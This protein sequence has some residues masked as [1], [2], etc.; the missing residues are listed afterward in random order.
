MKKFR[1]FSLNKSFRQF[2]S[3]IAKNCS[4]KR[5]KILFNFVAGLLVVLLFGSNIPLGKL[6]LSLFS[7]PVLAEGS[8]QINDS[9]ETGLQHLYEYGN[10]TDV[11]GTTRFQAINKPVYVDIFTAG[12]VINIFACT[13][14]ALKTLR[15]EIYSPVSNPTSGGS[16]GSLVYTTAD[17]DSVSGINSNDIPSPFQGNVESGGDGWTDATGD[18]TRANL[19]SSL[20][21]PLKYTTTT[22]GA[23]EVRF[24]ND[25]DADTMASV[26]QN[27]SISL[28]DITV[29]ANTS[30]APNPQTKQGRVWAFNWAFYSAA[31]N[32]TNATDHNYYIVVP[33]GFSGTN[34]VWQLDL[35][36]FAGGLYE[37]IANNSG[38]NSPNSSGQ[39]VRGLSTSFTGNTASSQYRQYIEYPD[40]RSISPEPASAPVIT[41]FRFEDSAGEDNTISPSSTTG[42]QDSGNFKFTTNTDG[43]YAVIIDVDNDALT[44]N[45]FNPDGQYG[46]GDIILRGNTTG[47]VETS[48][49]WNGKT[50]LGVAVPDGKYQARLYAITGEYHF[51]AGD[52]ESSGGTGLGLTINKANYGSTPSSV[53]TT[54]TEVYWDDMTGLGLAASN[55]TRPSSSLVSGYNSLGAR[56][57][58]GGSSA[59][60]GGN[61]ST[62]APDGASTGYGGN[63]AGFGD[64][65]YLDTYVYGKVTVAETPAIILSS[66]AYVDTP[67][68]DFGDAP[69]TY[70]TNKT[71]SNDG[72]TNTDGVGPSHSIDP[73]ALNLYLG[74]NAPDGESDARTPLTGTGD[75]TGGSTPDDEDGVA[76]FAAIN[77]ATTSY[78]V[79]VKVKNSSGK[80]AYLVGWID[81]NKN[82]KFDSTEGLAYD[83]DNNSTNGTTA[84]ATGTDGNVTLNWTGLSGLVS[85]TTYARFRIS[86]NS[87]LTTSTP[88]GAFIDGEVE[89]YSLTI[90]SA[91]PKLLLVKRITSINNDSAKNPNDNTALNVFVND[92][93]S[94]D[95]DNANWP[96]PKD[97]YLPGAIDGGNVK[98]GDEIEYTIYFLNTVTAAK[99]V[100]MCDLVPTN[101][102]FVQTTYNANSGIGLALNS[103]TLPTAPNSLLTNAADTDAGR[104]YATNDASTPTVCKKFDSSGAVASSGQ[105]AN[106]NGAIVVNVVSGT[107]TLPSA[108][109]AGTPTNS[110]GFVR[111]RAKVN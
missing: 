105:T 29:T 26:T 38:V 70:T 95:D 83:S 12:E 69:D 5:Q 15:V 96:T 21:K 78:S 99:N 63:G 109:A 8:Y 73:T 88:N 3:A 11:G 82:G 33:G 25:S 10:R 48:F 54:T 110:Y 13:N 50:N 27:G 49:S 98:P 67:L 87:G 93:G 2:L 14:Y 81:F 32:D 66:G 80:G 23:Y 65:R 71:P 76:S 6:G 111:F 41:N 103:T 94:T 55:S 90:T 44:S 1:P 58:W 20:L 108:T 60:G 51:L 7:S 36:N 52:V 43:T 62:G 39:I 89:D 79:T 61:G 102:T 72:V 100:T 35:N 92:S 30:T 77:T 4:I 37:I 40:S 28:F 68:L 9:G 106:T 86:T 46:I 104:Y 75:D 84:I 107:T 24:Y 64:L 19:T 42:I 57:T 34:F 47:G 91:Q 45:G 53:S 16:S 74:T 97:T 31:W 22:T 101:Q 85:G 56:H 17:R 59:D 18:C